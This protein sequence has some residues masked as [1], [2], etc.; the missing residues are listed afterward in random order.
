[1]HAGSQQVSNIIQHDF[2]FSSRQ[3]C[4][5]IWET[6]RGILLVIT[7]AFKKKEK[8]KKEY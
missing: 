7:S 6:F 4:K 8:K 1:M 5:A 3:H 2:F